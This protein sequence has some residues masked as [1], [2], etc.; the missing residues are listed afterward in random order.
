MTT[1][2]DRSVLIM[3]I[4]WHYYFH[5]MNVSILHLK[6]EYGTRSKSHFTCYSHCCVTW[7]PIMTGSVTSQCCFQG[8]LCSWHS[9]PHTFNIGV[10]KSSKK[11]STAII[12]IYNEF[13][14]LIHS[15]KVASDTNDW[16][17]SHKRC[18]W[19]AWRGARLRYTL[20]CLMPG[21]CIA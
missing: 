6:V 21:I 19:W 8:T 20:D 7:C 9:L 5:C 16:W 4:K 13:A 17:I 2:P 12:H 10:F 11:N 18:Q 3:I 14:N 15:C 1:K